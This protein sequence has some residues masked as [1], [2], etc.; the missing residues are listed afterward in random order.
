MTTQR[1]GELVSE[2]MR[3]LYLWSLHKTSDPYKAEDL[4][5][6]IIL[7]VLKSAPNLKCDDAFFGF[8]WKVAAN[9]YKQYLRKISKSETAELDEETAD[10]ADFEDDLEEKEGVSH[11]PTFKPKAVNGKRLVAANHY[12]KNFYNVVVSDTPGKREGKYSSAGARV[13]VGKISNLH[14]GLL[15]R[16]NADKGH[17]GKIRPYD[18]DG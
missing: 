9:T 11:P 18:A 4:C 10:Q 14:R 8:V 15:L 7:A 13:F 1:A 12:A 16:K 3:T 6:D 17:R 5:S 2:N